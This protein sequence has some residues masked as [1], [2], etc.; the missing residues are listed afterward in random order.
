MNNCNSFH[1]GDV[2]RLV[3]PKNES[4]SMLEKYN[5]HTFVVNTRKKVYGI[6]HYEY[7]YT[8]RGVMSKYGIHYTISPDWLILVARREDVK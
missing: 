2:V 6:N 8:L 3:L 1:P 4:V 5:K 7:T